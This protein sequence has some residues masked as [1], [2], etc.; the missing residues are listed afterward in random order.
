[1][2]YRLMIVAA[3]L[4]VAG[5]SKPPEQAVSSARLESVPPIPPP[6]AADSLALK[7]GLWLVTYARP[8]MGYSSLQKIC[9]D[10]AGGRSLAERNDAL[11]AMDCSRR[12]VEANSGNTHIERV[13]A[14]NGTTVTSHIDIAL[15][16]ENAFHQT[17]ETIYDPAFAGHADTHTSADGVW[18]G[19]CP[20]GMKPGDIAL[21]DGS[22]ATLGQ[23][24]A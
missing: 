24:P 13:C 6:P 4:A 1:M 22:K 17:M 14:R 15:D 21:P 10:A 12:Q 2:G 19:A 5:C 8:E 20:D 16:G 7:A 9:V 18:S 11:D 3:L 23:K